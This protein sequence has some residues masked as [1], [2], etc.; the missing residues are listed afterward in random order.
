MIKMNKE[1]S[2]M[3]LKKS[4]MSFVLM[5]CVGSAFSAVEL[6]DPSNLQH[7]Q[8]LQSL[9]DQFEAERD[10]RVAQMGSSLEDRRSGFKLTMEM[11]S[12]SKITLPVT[13][14]TPRENLG[15]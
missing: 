5:I 10:S 4:L 3:N 9:S 14:V 15:F 6:L 7:T 12:S 11:F 13:E 1:I 8:R 2:V